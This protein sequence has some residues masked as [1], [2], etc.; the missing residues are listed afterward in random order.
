MAG[1]IQLI[2]DDQGLAVIGDA[3]A[4]ERLL[5]SA[6]LWVGSRE[7]DLRRL[8]SVLRAGSDVAQTASEIVAG[9]GRWI[10]LTEESAR[11]VREHGLM[12][13]KET[14]IAHV[15][16]GT[17]GKIASWLQTDQRMGTLLSN[18]AALSG[19]AGLLSQ[20]AAQQS[21]AEIRDYLVTIDWKV[22]D[23]R[24]KQ[25]SDVVSR[26]AGVGASIDRAMTIRDAVGE[27]DETL[28]STVQHSHTTIGGTQ[29][30][31]LD[32]L[33]NIAVTLQ[34][35]RMRELARSATRAEPE[36]EKWLGVLARC[37]Q[38]EEALDVLELDR[39]MTQALEPA[40]LDDYRRAQEL[41]LQRRRQIIGQRTEHLLAAMDRAVG[42]ANEKIL[43]T[44]DKSLGVV[45][46][47]NLIATGVDTFHGLLRIE[48]APRAWTPRDL[49]MVADVGSQTIEKVKK[50]TPAVGAVAGTAAVL[51][52]VGSKIQNAREAD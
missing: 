12:P 35:P 29:R 9:S 52:V 45:Q 33:D 26:L 41:A 16:V 6:G 3:T 36:V 38:L 34:S 42:T 31:A 13:T 23:I 40:R 20:A 1:D 17:P 32:E 22:D 51:L 30:Y 11:L 39:R 18:P 5:R 46:S 21:M 14:G 8:S 15:M 7:L 49:G 4:V 44:R 43:W 50:A 28:W 25:D 27:V 2:K 48:A 37:F 24:R 10:K 19:V 47:A